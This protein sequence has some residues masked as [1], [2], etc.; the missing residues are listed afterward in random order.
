MGFFYTSFRLYT[1]V[2][3]SAFL[4]AVPSFFARAEEVTITTERLEWQLPMGGQSYSS[5]SVRASNRKQ[6]T[7]LES[8]NGEVTIAGKTGQSF[9]VCATSLNSES[10]YQ[11]AYIAVPV[12]SLD[13]NADSNTEINI[14]A[15]TL[16]E[17]TGKLTITQSQPC[18]EHFKPQYP[19]ASEQYIRSDTP[20]FV[21]SKRE[22][23]RTDRTQDNQNNDVITPVSFPIN[24]KSLASLSGGGYDADDQNDYKRPPFMPAP[25]KAMANLILLPTL[26][27]PANWRDYLPFNGLYHWLTDT[28]YEGVT[29]LVRF[30]NM[31]VITF[32]ISQA[33]SRE[34]AEHL[35]NAQQLLHWL[36]PKL[37]GREQLIQQLL[38]WSADSGEQTSLLSEETLKSIRKRLA[39][40]LEQSDTEFS[41]TFESQLNSQLNSQ[42]KTQLPPGSIQLGTTQSTMTHN[43]AAGGNTGGQRRSDIPA[44]KQDG[45]KIQKESGYNPTSETKHKEPD[46]AFSG[47]VPYYTI[48][49]HQT[50]YHVSKMHVLANLD[51][52]ASQTDLRL[53]CLDCQQGGIPLRDMLSHAENHW[54]TSNQCQPVEPT[55]NTAEAHQRMLQ[56]HTQCK[57]YPG[58]LLAEPLRDK[59]LSIFRLMIRFGTEE[60][61]LDLLQQLD[62]PVTAEDLRQTD[63]CQRTM[64]HDLTQYSSPK[65]L[66]AFL[67]R[68]KQWITTNLLQLFDDNG[69]TPA[70][71][72]F[73]CQP[74][75]TIVE[76][77]RQCDQYLIPYELL[78]SHN[79]RGSTLLHILYHR[80]FFPLVAEVFYGILNQMIPTLHQG[81][82]TQQDVTG[83]NLMHIL[84]ACDDERPICDFIHQYSHQ[85]TSAELGAEARNGETPLHTLF[86]RGPLSAIKMLI[87]TCPTHLTS[88]PLS[89]RRH[90]DGYTPIHLL[91]ARGNTALTKIFLDRRFYHID[92]DLATTTN[93]A[94][95]SVLQ[96]LL[97]HC[98]PA[99][100][101]SWLHQ[102]IPKRK[103][104]LSS[105]LKSNSITW[106]ELLSHA[107]QHQF[108]TPQLDWVMKELEGADVKKRPVKP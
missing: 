14:Y 68:F 29:I 43:A 60:T 54:Q 83:L 75:Q 35:L 93:R 84:F 26:N 9:I 57:E 16:S 39:I 44:G 48:R 38:D 63:L 65:V 24:P 46:T 94:G 90:S 31:P 105:F 73:Q 2:F 22:S 88:N 100:A 103:Q 15:L 66:Q 47:P 78:S 69:W 56:S 27:L 12:I 82:L 42:D 96:A 36:A 11:G 18:P 6:V 8:F 76:T 21:M 61:Q 85:I 106:P 52:P 1:V 41:L 17:E 91:F 25:D 7:Q 102:G 3:L 50:K 58:R 13:S 87:D 80:G 77:M 32:R 40:V 79:H 59:F 49:L 45:K 107:K 5:L 34:L 55:A 23:K 10:F 62:L 104:F 70:H 81:L 51:K 53:F 108:T 19:I 67:Q 86:G 98:P 30:D 28:K 71:Y 95:D 74:E 72:L 37:S 4:S 92:R 99:A 20:F 33:E 89:K 64:L 101:L 97:K